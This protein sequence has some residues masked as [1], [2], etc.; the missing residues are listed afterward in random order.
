MIK[1]ELIKKYNPEIIKEKNNIIWILTKNDIYFFKNNDWN[2]KQLFSFSFNWTFD[3]INR[4]KIEIK[5]EKETLFNLLFNCLNNKWFPYNLKYVPWYYF[6]FWYNDNE[7]N[8]ELEES[9]HDSAWP[10]WWSWII[11]ENWI[12]EV[13]AY[14]KNYNN[15]YERKLLLTANDAV[16]FH[17]FDPFNIWVTDA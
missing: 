5:K 4:E 12:Y 17:V 9:D 16:E 7:E 11:W 2:D 3:N 15:E 13:Y 1:E 8:I 14:A 6:Y 10:F